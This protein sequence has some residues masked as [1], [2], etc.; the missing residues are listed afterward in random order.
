MILL[1]LAPIFWK[2]LFDF[3]P[4]RFPFRFD[5]PQIWTCTLA[6]MRSASFEL[7][8]LYLPMIHLYVL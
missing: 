2:L 5:N 1:T 3:G 6:L 4:H 8:Q 7:N